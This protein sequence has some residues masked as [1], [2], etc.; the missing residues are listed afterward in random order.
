MHD[1]SEIAWS[2]GSGHTTGE[3]G[4]VCL[5]GIQEKTLT[6]GSW[7]SDSKLLDKAGRAHPGPF[8]W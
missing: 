6:C 5:V 4:Y 1:A 8:P 7:Q 3:N 2:S